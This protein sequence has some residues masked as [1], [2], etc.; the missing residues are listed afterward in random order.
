M[1]VRDYLF[2]VAFCLDVPN[3][4]EVAIFEDLLSHGWIH[5]LK[6]KKNC[7]VQTFSKI[8][9]RAMKG[10]CSNGLQQ[11]SKPRLGAF[12]HTKPELRN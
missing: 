11:Q 9:P 3:D 1:R 7:L 4:F 8:A 2:A 12:W 5:F 10:E 6:S